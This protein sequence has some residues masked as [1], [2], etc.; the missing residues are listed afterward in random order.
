MD[1]KSKDHQVRIHFLWLW[2]SDFQK[3]GHNG[4]KAAS[5]LLCSSGLSL[6][7]AVRG[8]TGFGLSSTAASSPSLCAGGLEQSLGS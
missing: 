4:W 2:R 7:A 5:C 8:Q 3:L 1:E 6:H